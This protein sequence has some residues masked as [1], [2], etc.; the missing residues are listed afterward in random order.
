MKIKL[1]LKYERLNF[2]NGSKTQNQS[3]KKEEKREVSWYEFDLGMHGF[4]YYEDSC[5]YDD[6]QKLLWLYFSWW[7]FGTMF[8][9]IFD[10]IKIIKE[11]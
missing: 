2:R 8:L 5:G 9:F 10:W 7:T 3:N 1:K 4:S 11:C 6:L